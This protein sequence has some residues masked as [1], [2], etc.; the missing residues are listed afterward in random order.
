MCYFLTLGVPDSS[1]GLL[2]VKFG[3]GFELLPTSNPSICR[4]L[5]ASFRTLLLTSG[6]C[7]CDLYA[8][9]GGRP[10]EMSAEAQMARYRKRGWPGAKIE[11]AV[12]ASAG[13]RTGPFGFSGLRADIAARIAAIVQGGVPIALVVHWYSGEVELEK[14]AIVP[15]P[16][17]RG[18]SLRD[19]ADSFPEDTLI[20]V[21][22]A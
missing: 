10:P 3:R 21:D 22:P 19:G 9:P 18:P 13:A 7:S 14:F 1:V 6:M 8:K 4:V 20:W 16:H 2:R 12:Q 15:G 17:H 5:P 11:R